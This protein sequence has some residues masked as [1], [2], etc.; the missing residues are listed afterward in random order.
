MTGRWS[1]KISAPLLEGVPTS[2]ALEEE[3]R[4]GLIKLNIYKSYDLF[5]LLLGAHSQDAL[6]HSHGC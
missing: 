1:V 6:A 3:L 4:N 2:L 5:T